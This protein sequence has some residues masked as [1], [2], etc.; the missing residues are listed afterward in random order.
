MEPDQRRTAENVRTD[1]GDPQPERANGYRV[2]VSGE[3]KPS[4]R[5]EFATAVLEGLSEKPKRLPSR[6][7]Y[8]DQGS[9]YFQQ[10]MALPEY[11]PTRCEASILQ[12]H[13]GAILSRFSNQP[14]NLVDLGAG[15][16][17]KTIHLL[18]HLAAADADVSFIPIDISESAMA[19]LTNRVR[20]ELPGIRV[21]G[22]VSDYS[23]GLRW[24]RAHSKGRRNLVLFLGSNIGNF[25]RS[26]AR[27]FLRRLWSTLDTDDG[28]FLG[29]DLKKDIDLL[30]RAYNDSKGITAAFNLN[31]LERINRE[32]GGHFDTS[33]FRHFATYDVYSGA[34]ESYLV[35]LEQQTV[36][37]DALHTE[38]PFQ[39]WDP[40][41]TEYSY[42]YLDTDIVGLAK[43][44]G[45]VI[46]NT[47]HDDDRWFAGSLWRVRKKRR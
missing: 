37:V 31:L 36:A 17:A 19:G 29:F 2:L 30:L 28:V 16:G 11:Y 24:I 39:A 7:F 13:A 23:T 47:F 41:H 38:F 21:E 34:M 1:E 6:F 40:V 33:R 27:R 3:V 44:T 9:R 46:E 22:L 5:D 15:D 8:D 26:N 12:Q 42:K 32:L 25:D 14:L 4:P 10:I 20:K 43:G 45:F 18:R 35:S